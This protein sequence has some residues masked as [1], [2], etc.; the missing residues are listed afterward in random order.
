MKVDSGHDLLWVNAEFVGRAINNS[1]VCLMGHEPVDIGGAIAGS[2]ESLLDHIGDHRHGMT[3][4]FTS[5]HPQM[6][7][8]SGGRRAAVNIEF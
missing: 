7:D 6:A 2:F 5:F 4:D 3:K 1:L 8:G